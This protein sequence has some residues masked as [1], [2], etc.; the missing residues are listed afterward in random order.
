M[1]ARGGAASATGMANFLLA[2]EILFFSILAQYFTTPMLQ[3]SQLLPGNILQSQGMA[4]FVMGTPGQTGGAIQLAA[5]PAGGAGMQMGGL[6][7]Q[8]ILIPAQDGSLQLAY[9]LAQPM[10]NTQMQYQFITQPVVQES[11]TT[12]VIPA[13]TSTIQVQEP[14]I[15]HINEEVNNHQI[16]HIIVDNGTNT[17]QQEE[18]VRETTPPQSTLD[19]PQRQCIIEF[20][21][22]MSPGSEQPQHHIASISYQQHPSPPQSSGEQSSTSP[23][24]KLKGTQYTI[25]AR[26]F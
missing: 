26:L 12:S 20:V 16:S 6:S 3:P 24:M 21:D 2:K 13:E 17:Q 8:P 7:M 15:N 19:D 9:H 25:I 23:T 14:E 10:D 1:E 22:N 4:T 11:P 18:N 5:P